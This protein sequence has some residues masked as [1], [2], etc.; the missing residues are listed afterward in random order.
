[1][2]KFLVIGGLH[3]NEPLGIELCRR[4]ENLKLPYIDVLYGNQKAIRYNKR[5]IEQDLNRVFP[6]NTK[7]YEGR[8]AKQIMTL[9]KKYDFVID[10]HNT[11]CP[12]NNCGF[13]G[14]QGWGKASKLASFL[15]LKKL[16]VADYDCINKYVKNCLSVEISLGD[17]LCN[18][19]YWVEKLLSL[20]SFKTDEAF[21]KI[22]LYKFAYRITR[23]QQNKFNFPVWRVFKPAPKKD[24]DKLGLNGKYYP[25]FVDDSYTPYNYAGLIQKLKLFTPIS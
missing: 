10:F 20:R 6:G 12:G 4:L 13:V 16:I 22:E 9:C 7:S 1:M 14:G 11:N 15:K 5:F 18:A 21:G 19:D 2:Y 24:L 23:E 17:R 8:R 3:G 25:I